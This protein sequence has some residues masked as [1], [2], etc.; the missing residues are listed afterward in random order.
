M[1]KL[2]LWLIVMLVGISM[3]G[4][5]S[6][7]GCKAEEAAPE[8]EVA[9]EEEAAVAE[10]T[11]APAKRFKIGAIVPTLDAQFWNRYYEFIRRVRV[12]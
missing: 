10:T 8:E 5:F 2:L 9:E 7:A 12:N 6:I 1:K 11:A 3:I 4:T